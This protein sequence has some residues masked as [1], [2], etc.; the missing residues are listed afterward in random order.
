MI[1]R[2]LER[3]Y[4]REVKIT[5]IFHIYFLDLKKKL[6]QPQLKHLVAASVRQKT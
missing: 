3:K 2:L 1:L 6:T 5:K 4:S